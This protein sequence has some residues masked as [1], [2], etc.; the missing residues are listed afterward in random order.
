MMMKITAKYLILASA[1]VIGSCEQK[2]QS[3][4]DYLANYNRDDFS[5]QIEANKSLGLGQYEMKGES[6]QEL[7]IKLKISS[8]SALT[9]LKITKTKNLTIDNSFGNSGSMSIPVSGNTFSYDLTYTAISSDVDELIGL[10]FEAVNA[11]GQK[12]V[13]DLTL[14]ITLSPR[15]NLPRR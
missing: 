2:Y 3:P 7:P 13:S 1:F 10:T 8:P 5:I 12:E 6:G 15:D 14:K 11:A 4:D 9:D